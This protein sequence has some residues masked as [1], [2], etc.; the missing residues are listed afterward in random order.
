M[1]PETFKSSIKWMKNIKVSFTV[2]KKSPSSKR[3][4]FSILYTARKDSKFS[5]PV[6]NTYIFIL[7]RHTYHR[8]PKNDKLP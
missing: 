8:S 2:N 7:K 1:L 6:E 3:Q 5:L 4:F